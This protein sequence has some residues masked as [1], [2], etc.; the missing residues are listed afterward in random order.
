MKFELLRAESVYEGRAFHVRRD[1]LRT[2][3]G[4]TV[5]YDIIEHTGSVI[6]IPVDDEGQMYFVRQYRHA[7]QVE[8][9]ELPAGTLEPG[10]PPA[11]AAAREI[12]EEIGME[13]QHL[14]EIGAFYLAPGYSTELMHVFLAR[15]LK[16][17]PLEA[18]ADEFLSVETLSVAEAFQQAERG[19]LQDAK[20]LAALLL[21]KQ[22]LSP[23]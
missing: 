14:E 21:A 20:T 18:D 12:R 22:H 8:L 6:L 3:D 7:A 16:H 17:N 9:L 11:E 15:G 1:H 5:K 10:E 13:A 4:R 2:P 19:A 23:A